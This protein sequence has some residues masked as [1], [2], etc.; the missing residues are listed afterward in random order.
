MASATS[1]ANIANAVVMLTHGLNKLVFLL[2]DS[3]IQQLYLDNQF[4]LLELPTYIY[5]GVQTLN[6]GYTAVSSTQTL[7]D[8]SV[9]LEKLPVYI[10]AFMTQ[11]SMI[12]PVIADNYNTYISGG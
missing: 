3:T 12:E 4:L 8:K 11:L 6:L 9:S 10:G 1:Y 5:Q 7:L 2:G